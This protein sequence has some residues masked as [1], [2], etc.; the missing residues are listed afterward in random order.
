MAP[1]T[2]TILLSPS[3]RTIWAVPLSAHVTGSTLFTETPFDLKLFKMT[4]P[5]LSS[6]TRPTILTSAPSRAAATAWLA[7]FPPGTILKLSPST[8]SPAPGRLL[9]VTTRS[10]AQLPITPILTILIHLSCRIPLGKAYWHLNII[11][12]RIPML[13][14]FN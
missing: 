7:P 12:M 3:A 6:P 10:T 9:E 8:V 13:H 11:V 2:T 4:S 1:L 5:K 14:K